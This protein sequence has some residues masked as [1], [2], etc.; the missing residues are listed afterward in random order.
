M[1]QVNVSN[2]KPKSK[3]DILLSII[4][5]E[6]LLHNIQDVDILLEQ[7][8]TEARKVV[9]ADAGSIYVAENN[10]LS[11]RYAQ[12]DTLRKRLAPE[13]TQPYIFFSFPIDKTSIA[14]CAG[15]TKKTINEPDVY[16]IPPS[17]SY[18]FSSETDKKTG[19]KT[20]SNL[21]IPLL[22]VSGSL[23]G[24]LQVLNAL[25]ENGNV[26][27]FSKDDET[28]LKYFAYNAG[29]ALERSYMMHA[30]IMRM[31]RV[32][33]MRDPKETGAH[34]NRVANYAVEIYDRWAFHKKLAHNK[35]AGYRDSFKIAAMLHDVGKIAIPDAILKKNEKLTAEEFEII[36]SHTWLGAKLFTS[37]DSKADELAAEI[38][39]RHHENWDGSGYPGHIC[40]ETGKPLI[41]DKATGSAQGLKGKE[42][43]LSARIVAIA[44]VYDALSCKRAYKEAWPEKNVIEEIKKE[45][46]R[47]FDPELVEL[48]FEVL[49]RI[50]AIKERFKDND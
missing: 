45:T 50:R 10:M 11:I 46:G 48:F 25:D 27:S 17:K 2:S 35:I 36:K 7:I 15:Y 1:R 18:K 38:V 40:I 47:K 29:T 6:T 28:Y 20:V 3:E 24:V 16:N 9:N 14:G 23:L 34:V 22:S 21:T 39:L 26:K 5:T 41:I 33:E 44:D 32:S 37:I 49:P 12:N 30:M 13:E 8:L 43:P 4:E 19:Y 42:I 31:I